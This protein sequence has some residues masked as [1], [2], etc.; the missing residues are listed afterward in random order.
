MLDRSP[1][2]PETTLNVADPPRAG[3]MGNTPAQPLR[4]M[5]KILSSKVSDSQ[6]SN[7]G[8]LSG[9]VSVYTSA[10]Q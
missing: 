4:G 2:F 6:S 5:T 10:V 9:G 7:A 3:S 1:S 8:G